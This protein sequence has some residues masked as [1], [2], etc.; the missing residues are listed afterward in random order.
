MTAFLVAILGGLA[1]P[2]PWC[3]ELPETPFAMTER[4]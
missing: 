3:R 2:R 4:L 1:I